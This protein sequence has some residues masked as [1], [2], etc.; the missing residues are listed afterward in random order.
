MTTPQPT[1]PNLTAPNPDEVQSAAIELILRRELSRRSLLVFTTT[2]NKSYDAGW[3]HKDICSRLEKFSQDVIDK[4][5]PRLMLFLPP[6]AGK[7]EL[8]SRNFPAWHL[9]HAPNH[10]IICAS[11][12]SSLAF[13]FSRSARDLCR[14]P[15]YAHI[16]PEAKLDEEAQNLE[17]WLTTSGGGYMAAGVG[18]PLT[19]NGCHVGIIDDSVKNRDEA[20]S[21]TVRQSIKDWYTS[22]FYTRL[23]PGAGILIIMTR[24][25]H[26]DLAGW[27]LEE[28]KNGGE[29]WEVVKYPA[30][31]IED[32]RYRRKGEALHPSRY[33]LPALER[34]KKA[35]GP[36]DW[37]ALYQ[38][39]PVPDTGEFFTRKEM[40][41]YSLEER[42]PLEQLSIYTAWDLAVGRKEANDYCAGITIGYDHLDRI[43]VLDIVR[44]RWG[45]LGLVDQILDQYERWRAGITGI[46]HGQISL[47][48]GPFLDKRVRE[49]KLYSFYIEPL[50]TGRADKEARARAIQGRLQQGM[51]LFPKDHPMLEVLIAE[52]LTFPSGLH[53]DLVDALAWI[54][55]MMVLFAPLTMAAEQP[56]KSW[57]D[58]LGRTKNVGGSFMGA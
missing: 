34:I 54:G 50:K 39:N 12:A 13:K 57:R 15:E 37:Q 28:A 21:E 14:D 32:E 36:R 53:D 22:T 7:S 56:K 30:I 26:D 17:N 9:G 33:P 52:M 8:A 47:S 40:R 27:L 3:V 23:A 46:E 48:I 35:V 20:E 43:W 49:R 16:F 10:E 2:F 6:R 19:G 29:Q 51:V 42:P 44:G 5:S 31:A 55:R 1:P 38:Q 41:F 58:K 4:K 11:Y 45:A 24:W 25:H 18:G